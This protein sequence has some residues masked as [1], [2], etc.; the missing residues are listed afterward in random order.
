M[1]EQKV[2]RKIEIPDNC[3]KCP[4]V[5]IKVDLHHREIYCH[6][7]DKTFVYQYKEVKPDFCKAI[8]VTIEEK[9]D[10]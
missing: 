1:P 7:Y 2:K 8:A 4:M 5:Q 9:E 10:E 3:H 6:V